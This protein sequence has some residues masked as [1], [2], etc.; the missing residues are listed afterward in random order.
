MINGTQFL[1]FFVISVFSLG[2]VKANAANSL[3]IN[4]GDTLYSSNDPDQAIGKYSQP[5]WTAE[6]L[7]PGTRSYVIAEKDLQSEFWVTGK[8]LN[9]GGGTEYIFQQ[10]IEYGIFTHLQLD[11]YIN[12]IL[13][14]GS[15]TTFQLE[16]AQFE[17]RW[18][19]ADWGKV[20][21]NPTLYLEYHPRYRNPDKTE[22]RL[23]LTETLAPKWHFASNLAVETE[24]SGA[25]AHE[26]AITTGVSRSIYQNVISIGVEAKGEW[27]DTLAT[28]GR[29][30][31]EYC[32]GPSI[33]W[34]PFGRFHVD[35]SGLIGLNSDANLMENIFILGYDF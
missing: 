32:V 24:L 14:A 17:L 23:L 3:N 22:V 31:G 9:N 25:L 13:P 11:F 1:F 28:R 29:L 6:R 2:I 34:K 8:T 26:Y 15:G 12:E 5:R 16:G 35:Y 4:D 20:F 30:V 7:F 21:L 19:W 27:S 10:E 18:A 33:Q